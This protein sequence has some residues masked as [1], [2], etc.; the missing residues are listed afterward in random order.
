MF[1][2]YLILR[3]AHILGAV[4]L[5]GGTLFWRVAF[6]PAVQELP[7]D[8]RA[9][10]NSALRRRWSRL[11]MLAS[12]LLLVSGLINFMTIVTSYDLVKD[13]L[14]GRLYHPLFG[15]KFLLSLVVFLLASLLAGRS[16]AAERMRQKERFWLSLN[17]VLA[18]LVVC[19]G[20]LLRAADR[21]PKAATSARSA[22]RPAA[23]Q[24]AT[25]MTGIP[26]PVPG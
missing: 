16:G 25:G 2:L 13:D 9:N 24:H 10:L 18:I 8:L 21:Q 4:L 11:V 7:E 15:V 19:L 1:T 26:S 6:W 22:E 14:P 17:A 23:V 5:V 20:G 12:G 3:W